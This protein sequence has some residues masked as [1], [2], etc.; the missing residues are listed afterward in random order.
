MRNI[1]MWVALFI[2]G[3]IISIKINTYL[4]SVFTFIAGWNYKMLLKGE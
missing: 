2:A 1:I 4:G 3:L